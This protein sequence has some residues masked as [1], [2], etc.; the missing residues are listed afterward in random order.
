MFSYLGRYGLNFST[1]FSVGNEANIDIVECMEYLAQCPNTRVI[2]LYIETIRR[3]RAFIEAARRIAPQK[4]IVAYYTGGTEAGRRAGLSHTG[5]LAG[6]DRVYDGVFRQSGVLRAHS[7]ES[8]FDYC[9][10]LG[11][12]PVPRSNRVFI[13]TNSGGPGAVAADAC[14]RAGL[15]LPAVADSTRQRLSEFVPRTASLNNPV[16]LTFTR[17]NL[18]YFESIPAAL[19]EDEKMDALLMYLMMP[20]R[21][22]VLAMES[23]GVAKEKIPGEVEKFMDGQSAEL[24]RMMKESAKPWIAFSYYSQENRFIRKLYEAGAPVLPGP[25]RAA[26]ALGAL[27]RY[28]L[29]RRKIAGEEDSREG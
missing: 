17:N 25:H 12:C 9:W 7:I 2:G 21:N 13:L 18:D 23:M 8:L 16:D 1:G 26:D 10:C 29:L 11:T 4:P 22:I 3:G 15:E 24:A 6:A 19:Q 28:A 20:R 5:A 14:A 27:W